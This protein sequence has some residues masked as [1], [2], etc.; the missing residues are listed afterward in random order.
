M[1]PRAM[2]SRDPYARPHTHYIHQRYNMIPLEDLQKNAVRWCVKLA[3]DCDLPP[4]LLPTKVVKD[5]ETKT[6]KIYNNRSEG[7][8]S[9]TTVQMA[10]VSAIAA[11]IYIHGLRPQDVYEAALENEAARHRGRGISTP[12]TLSATQ[13]TENPSPSPPAPPTSPSPSKSAGA[14]GDP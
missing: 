13:N 6:L 11:L 14:R 8:S 9:I 7:F 12:I 4:A 5:L 2:V 10:A 1:P 3:L